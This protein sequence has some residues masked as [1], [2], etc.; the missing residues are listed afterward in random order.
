MIVHFKPTKVVEMSSRHNPTMSFLLKL[1][2]VPSVSSPTEAITRPSAMISKV[3]L[4]VYENC[5]NPKIT[6]Q[7]KVKIGPAPVR[8]VRK[9]TV[10]N[11]TALFPHP[12]WNPD[13]IPMG[14][15]YR[16]KIA[17][18]GS[19][20]MWL[21]LVQPIRDTTRAQTVARLFEK[22]VT[23]K[24]YGKCVVNNHFVKK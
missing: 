7:P 24:G 19:R 4:I 12:S 2:V 5:S 16:R 1:A 13:T 21:S 23:V 14:S 15:T 11:C 17:G 8:I 6:P 18:E 20:G 3:V 9:E 10:N 22:H